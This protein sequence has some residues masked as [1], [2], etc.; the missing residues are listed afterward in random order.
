[1]A[2][3]LE[4][5]LQHNSSIEHPGLI[6][7]RMDWL[8]LLAV[9]GTVKSLLQHHSS[10]A[11]IFWHSALVPPKRKMI[12][13]R[14]IA[15]KL[16]LYCTCMIFQFLKSLGCPPSTQNL[17]MFKGREFRC[18]LFWLFHITNNI[19]FIL[20]WFSW[21]I[22]MIIKINKFSFLFVAFFQ[23]NLCSLQIVLFNIALIYI[24]FFFNKLGL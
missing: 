7:F 15:S 10:K 4:F 13:I 12:E 19:L 22:N 18:K 14:G 2:K 16:V 11:S 8:D 9:Q 6:S 24:F 3:V 20:N 5:Q 1:M 21:H 23:V 17:S